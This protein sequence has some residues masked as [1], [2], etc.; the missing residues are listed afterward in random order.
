MAFGDNKGVLQ[1][2]AASVPAAPAINT[3]LS[4]SAAVNIG[5]LVVAVF[6][7]Q[8]TTVGVVLGATA[9]DNLGHTY[10]ALNAGTDAGVLELRAYWTRITS[11]GT[12]TAITGSAGAGSGN[13]WCGVA[14]IY[15]GPFDTSPLDANPANV[16]NDTTS[17]F[18][19]TSTGTL[20]QAAELAVCFF[21]KNG[22]G[23]WAAQSPLLKDNEQPTASI[24][25]CG[26][27]HQVTAATTA[28]APA[29]TGTATTDV[30]GVATF[31]RD[32]LQVEVT[33]WGF[34]EEG[35]ESGAAQ[36]G[37]NN[38]AYEQPLSA[39]KTLGLRF[40][41][42][43]KG[44][45][46]GAPATDD[47]QLQVNL[48]FAGQTNVTTTSQA[49]QAFASAS[50]TDA[51]ATTNRLGAG[52]G[53]FVA[54]KVS[55]D[56]LVDDVGV[57]AGNFTEILFSLAID[58]A[59]TFRNTA[60]QF[61]VLRNGAAMTMNA[62]PS[63]TL[64]D[65][66]GTRPTEFEPYSFSTASS[67]LTGETINGTLAA[68]GSGLGTW[69][70]Q[71]LGN[72]GVVVASFFTAA[73]DPG[74][75]GLSTKEFET[76]VNV[77]SGNSF[78]RLAARAVRVDASGAVQAEGPLSEF[79]TAGA[80]DLIFYPPPIGLGAWNAGDRAR[81]DLALFNATANT[82]QSCTISLVNSDFHARWTDTLGGWNPVDKGGGTLTVSAD[83]R[84]VTSTQTS[85]TL[86]GNI[87]AAARRTL[88]DNAK[89]YFEAQGRNS[90]AANSTVAL[91]L[92]SK[93]A[94]LN[95]YLGAASHVSMGTWDTI[96]GLVSGIVYNAAN[97]FTT[98]SPAVHDD[99]NFAIAIDWLNKRFWFKA[100]PSGNWNNSGTANPAT[101]VGGFDLSQL[102]A[103][104]ELYIA[105]LVDDSSSTPDDAWILNMGH[106][107]YVGAIPSGFTEWTV[108]E[109][110]IES[111][112]LSVAGAGAAS[113]AGTAIRAGALASAGTATAALVGSTA[114]TTVAGTLTAAG[115]AS[116]AAMGSTVLGRALTAAGS[117]T[118]TAT[119][120][121]V[122]GR[123]LAVAGTASA[124]FAAASTAAGA[125]AA[126]GVAGAA[127]AGT[128]IRAGV[129]ASAGM[130]TASLVGSVAGAAV[131]GTLTAAGSATVAATGSAVLGRPLAVAGTASASLVGA[132][133]AAAR[134][135][136]AGTATV[137]IVG[138][139]IAAGKVSAAG[140]AG[141]GFA[142]FGAAAGV[143]TF[144]A[145]GTGTLTATGAAR[146]AGALSAAGV[147]GVGVVGAATRAGALSAAGVAAA[148]LAA[149]MVRGAALSIG[150]TASAS[151]VGAARAAAVLMGAGS[152]SVAIAGSRVLS[153]ALAST[154]TG[155]FG[156]VGAALA[157]GQSTAAFTG[158]GAALA[159]GAAIHA[160]ALSVAGVA[161]VAAAGAQTIA[162]KATFAGAAGLAA[163]GAS[164][165]NYQA[166]AL[167][168]G[169]AATV[170]GKGSARAAAALSAAGAASVAPRAT[171]ITPAKATFAGAAVAA[172]PTVPRR[173]T[174]IG[175]TRTSP[176]VYQRPDAVS[177]AQRSAAVPPR[178]RASEG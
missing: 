172:F 23:T 26:I 24:Q 118:V 171:A 19:A 18:T 163:V 99:P 158:V 112:A 151:L 61:R 140:T 134:L 155:T 126:S 175:R 74:A 161:T 157:T 124:T 113:F 54:G 147:A 35:S 51:G 116:L 119:G 15:E 109:A 32:P 21:A 30:I 29:W 141:V 144:L 138:A 82:G 12:I 64:S 73:G 149:S 137:S 100:L 125:V 37:A 59:R 83:R 27:G 40:R 31:R 173:Q 33:A 166:G 52:T 25:S 123:P 164:L 152:S 127:F 5:D 63:I 139:A 13:N 20:A 115:S 90:A 142:G 41:V 162:A 1:G 136:S 16:A 34:F 129:L 107:A 93:T 8:S 117:A 174:T 38:A 84:T 91:G 72:L 165:A 148:N 114:G 94:A 178:R 3:V 97:S 79:Q 98:S 145:A 169:G 170:T 121:T 7:V 71:A 177:S 168:A 87:R 50:L 130:A 76:V 77:T 135:T 49:I 133:T 88:G 9:T 128:G 17:P 167:T 6:S 56:G 95:N 57:T 36:I 14:G 86:Y 70:A 110:V 47:Y 58:P 131:A 160:G 62:T 43:E 102:G 104:T 66:I 143:G 48:P 106:A 60:Y 153:G 22:S 28:I 101:N 46:I 53:S 65:E 150:G 11:A 103:T 4:G 156:A 67:G 44:G 2:N 42:Q 80:G 111:A 85:A 75:T 120:S 96:D 10:A 132:S 81:I 122:L 146:A 105:G 154:G 69:S 78:L 176:G 45:T 108:V 159:R 92:M 55:E 39:R 68:A 89:T